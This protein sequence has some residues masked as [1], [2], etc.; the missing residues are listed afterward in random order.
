MTK[1]R[2]V[3]DPEYAV[4]W[5]DPRRIFNQ[6]ETSMTAGSDHAKIL[7]PVGY[8]R[9]IYNLGGD[10]REH[11]SLSVTVSADGSF[12]S[13]RLVYKGVRNRTE[14]ISHIPKDGVTGEWLA[15]VA[16]EGYVTRDTFLEILNDLETHCQKENIPKPVCNRNHWFFVSESVLSGDSGTSVWLS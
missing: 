2:L 13:C 3:D 10:S 8:A 1:E 7:A 5:E 12:I 15:S 14:K 9:P 11:T 4:C 6:D 16:P